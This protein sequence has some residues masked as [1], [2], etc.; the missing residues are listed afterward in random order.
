MPVS[1]KHHSRKVVPSNPARI[2]TVMKIDKDVH[3]VTLDGVYAVSVAVEMF[4]ELLAQET[5][6]Y[7]IKEGRKVVMFKDVGIF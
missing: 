7:T 4:L 3:N 5:A 1:T 2:K 6:Q